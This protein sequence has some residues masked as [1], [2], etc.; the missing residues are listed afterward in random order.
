MASGTPPGMTYVMQL[1]CPFGLDQQPQ[2]HDPPIHFMQ[3]S[4]VLF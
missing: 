2:R 1:L 4:L 3:S